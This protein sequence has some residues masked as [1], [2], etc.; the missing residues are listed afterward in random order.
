MGD[1]HPIF[2]ESCGDDTG[3]HSISKPWVRDG[4]RYA[5][6][7]RILVW[8]KCNEPDT[9]GI[10][11]PNAALLIRDLVGKGKHESEPV[12]IPEFDFP[13]LMEMC[14][15]CNGRGLCDKCD[16]ETEHECGE[17]EGA[18]EVCRSLVPI[19]LADKYWV[20][21]LYLE[22][23]R[24]HGATV[25]LPKRKARAAYFTVECGIEGLVMPVDHT[26]PGFTGCK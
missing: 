25:Y 7:G 10:N 11:P 6:D 20:M 22:R 14:D 1:I 3:R 19:Q 5:T 9:P 18:G 24:R 8:Q 2:Y 21:D 23:L 17:C 12:A 16:C 4:V 26:H 13:P 15:N